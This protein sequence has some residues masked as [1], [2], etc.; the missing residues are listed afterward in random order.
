MKLITTVN[1]DESDKRLE[2]NVQSYTHVFLLCLFLKFSLDNS[3]NDG[4]LEILSL[5]LSS[6]AH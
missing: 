2:A 4:W 3:V 5:S 1:S 6:I